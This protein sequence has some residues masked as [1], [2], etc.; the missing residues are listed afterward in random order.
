MK[1]IKFHNRIMKIICF[2]YNSITELQNHENL[3][4]SRQNPEIQEILRIPHTE[5]RKL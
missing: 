1:F 2:F 3:I 5:L 4:I